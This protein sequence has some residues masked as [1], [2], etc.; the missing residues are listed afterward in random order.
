[1]L[2]HGD[3]RPH[4]ASGNGTPH[5]FREPLTGATHAPNHSPS[6]SS[7]HIWRPISHYLSFTASFSSLLS[8]LTTSAPLPVTIHC[9]FKGPMFT[10]QNHHPPL[11]TASELNNR[12]IQ[13][14]LMPPQV[15]QVLEPPALLQMRLPD[16][17][18]IAS[19]GA[20]TSSCQY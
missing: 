10:H 9:K 19:R 20:H 6:L 5:N 14:N 18:C 15:L 7:P 13:V 17:S 12:T 3:V 2:V 8:L 1:M 4:T 16:P 11:I